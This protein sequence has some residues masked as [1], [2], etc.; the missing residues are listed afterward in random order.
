MV[1]D[2]EEAIDLS[3]R[4][5]LFLPTLIFLPPRSPLP[6]LLFPPPPPP[7]SSTPSL[8][9]SPPSTSVRLPSSFCSS[10]SGSIKQ[11]LKLFTRP[12]A[13]GERISHWPHTLASCDFLMLVIMRAWY[14]FNVSDAQYVWAWEIIT[15]SSVCFSRVWS[16]D[17]AWVWLSDISG[18]WSWN[19]CGIDFNFCSFQSWNQAT[20]TGWFSYI[21]CATIVLMKE[22]LFA[23]SSL[24][25]SPHMSTP[26]PL[27]GPL[28][29]WPDNF[30][31]LNRDCWRGKEVV[32]WCTWAS[33]DK[34][35]Q[36]WVH[37][38]QEVRILICLHTT[39]LHSAELD[40]S[41]NRS[42]CSFERTSSSTVLA[43]GNLIWMC[44]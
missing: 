15:I 34:I 30:I 14:L 10:Q 41:F 13:T 42:N 31:M 26:V 19:C 17:C 24:T 23:R 35:K 28:W 21:M 9:L 37:S 18:L 1:I 7:P 5:T 25:P 20:P 38:L 22:T 33:N 6:V 29:C 36:R 40:T 8:H 39:K 27:G 12:L 44:S 43:K 16:V 2:Q 11:F 32:D 4:H 3:N